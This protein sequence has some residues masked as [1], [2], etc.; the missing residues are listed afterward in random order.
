MA[1]WVGQAALKLNELSI[2]LAS[3]NYSVDH[4]K[5][6]SEFT[7]LK[8]KFG[9][10]QIPSGDDVPKLSLYF[11]CLSNSVDI[12]TLPLE[13]ERT[14]AAAEDASEDAT[15]QTVYKVVVQVQVPIV[16]ACGKQIAYA[17]NQQGGPTDCSANWCSVSGWQYKD[18]HWLKVAKDT[19]VV[20]QRTGKV[21]NKLGGAAGR[22]AAWR[23]Q[24]TQFTGGGLELQVKQFVLVL[25]NR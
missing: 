16:S 17:T 4:L 10:H 19:W 14:A 12:E 11:P 18:S 20:Q 6:A 13:G 8:L 22:G 25:W 7:G 9:S 2:S 5:I 21:P 23:D 3:P 15:Q 1:P 24:S